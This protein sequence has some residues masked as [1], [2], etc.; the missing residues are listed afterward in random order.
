[1]ALFPV[2]AQDVDRDLLSANDMDTI[3]QGVDQRLR[4]GV[5]NVL[6]SIPLHSSRRL[7]E[8]C[9]SPMDIESHAKEQRTF[10]ISLHFVSHSMLLCCTVLYLRE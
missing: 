5:R 8:S 7:F 2:G 3:K 9:N 10:G 6:V 4:L 1:M